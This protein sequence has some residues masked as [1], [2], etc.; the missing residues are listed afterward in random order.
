M[1][2]H[3]RLFA[4][5]VCASLIAVGLRWRVEI[6]DLVPATQIGLQNVAVPE[7][8]NPRIAVEKSQLGEPG[9]AAHASTLA[10]LPGNRLSLTWFSGSRE[11]ASDVRIVQS[12]LIGEAWSSPRTLITKAAVGKDTFR[13]LRKLGNTVLHTDA[14]GTV[15]AFATSVSL[16]GW[17]GARIEHMR[18]LDGGNTWLAAK[19]LALSP[20]LNISTLSRAPALNL[21]GGGFVLPVYHEFLRKAPEWL[22]FDATGR[23]VR[24]QRLSFA[25]ET[26]QPSVFSS[27]AAPT[28]WR[29]LLRNDAAASSQ[30]LSVTSTDGRNFSAP[31]PTNLTNRDTS[32]AAIGLPNGLFAL[33]YNPLARGTLR[34]ALSKDGI[35]FTDFLSLE[36]ELGQ[37]FSYPALAIHQGRLWVSYTEKRAAIAVRSFDLATLVLPI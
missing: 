11:G 14:N 1:Q 9:Q 34:L 10:L 21:S 36:E 31:A 22:H 35:T 32:V 20:F 37:E 25:P 2:A 16:G 17:A 3:A 28:V 19:T 13:H 5:G 12:E 29:V 15:H 30:L 6:P 23:L 26:L 18:S 7:P 4:V 27:N 8:F 24:K 33:A